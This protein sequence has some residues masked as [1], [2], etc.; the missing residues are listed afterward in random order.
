MEACLL[1]LVGASTKEY[2]F[3]Y[4]NGVYTPLINMV[5]PLVHNNDIAVGNN[6][7]RP[8]YL[9]GILI[10]YFCLVLC[11]GLK[12]YVGRCFFSSTGC[13]VKEGE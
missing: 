7:R 6:N 12:Y 13:S 8:V 9:V 4:G 10:F 1:S 2:L 5:D 3:V 11:S